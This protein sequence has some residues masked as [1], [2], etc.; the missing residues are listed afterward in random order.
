MKENSRM[1]RETTL[2][3]K[4]GS[5]DK[6]SHPSHPNIHNGMFQNS[7]GPLQ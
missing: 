7:L 2:T 3:N 4:K 1:G 5:A 6:I